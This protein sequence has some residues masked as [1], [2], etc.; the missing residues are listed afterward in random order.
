MAHPHQ[1]AILIARPFAGES[2]MYNDMT[3]MAQG[4]VARGFLTDQIFCL[5]GRLDRPLV[6]SFVQA[7]SRRVAGWRDGSVFLHVSSHGF[8]TG[9]T[10]SEARA[11]LLLAAPSRSRATQAVVADD[12]HLFWDDLFAALA[13]PV[14]VT[15]TLLPDL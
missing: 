7:A 8:V 14:G 5:H 10:A 2:A 3:A 11:G 13:L 4:L 1:L 15:L 9:K 6:L 12:D